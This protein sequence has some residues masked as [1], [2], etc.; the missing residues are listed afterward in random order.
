[1][2]IMEIKEIN[3]NVVKYE[4]NGVQFNNKIEAQDYINS[5]KRYISDIRDSLEFNVSEDHFKLLKGMDWDWWDC[6]FG[7]PTVDCE[8]PYGSSDV[9]EDIAKILNIPFGLVDDEWYTDDQLEYMDKRHR[10]TE[11]YLQILF[12]F[13]EIPSGRYKRKSKRENWEK[14]D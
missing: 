2:V 6:E 9:Y 10:E 1:M 8:C 12:Y 11:T 5:E 13:G 4:V 7:S 14:V 3:V